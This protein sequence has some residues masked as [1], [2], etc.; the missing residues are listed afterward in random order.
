M[1]EMGLCAQIRPTVNETARWNMHFGHPRAV[2]IED[3]HNGMRSAH[4][5]TIEVFIEAVIDGVVDV[6]GIMAGDV[7]PGSGPFAFFSKG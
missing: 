6:V 2:A 4:A 3:S 1:S 7:T 5:A